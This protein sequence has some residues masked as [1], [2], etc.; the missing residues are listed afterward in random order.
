MKK[1]YFLLLLF[2]GSSLLHAQIGSLQSISP[3]FSIPGQNITTTIT[4]VGTVFQSSSPPNGINNIWLSGPSTISS[5]TWPFFTPLDDEHVDADFS[6]PVSAPI[7]AYDVNVEVTDG[8][9]FFTFYTLTLPGAFNVGTPDGYVQGNIYQ[10]ANGNGVK[11]GGEPDL[12]N[13]T[14]RIM[15]YNYT[16]QTDASGNYSFPVLNGTYTV[17]W[18]VNLNLFMLL[19][20]DSA[21]FTVT[22]NNDTISG[23]D[24]GLKGLLLSVTPNQALRGQTL[25]MSI[26]SDSAF[27][28]SIQQVYLEPMIGC[29]SIL[30]TSFSS[31]TADS[32]IATFN[33]P[34][35]SALGNYKL[36]V[37][38][39]NAPFYK[40]HFL[41]D[42]LAVINGDGA[43]SGFL[44]VDDNLN[45][46]HDA[47][48]PGATSQRIRVMPDNILS[49]TDVNGNYSMQVLN[50]THNVT[51][52]TDLTNILYVNSSPVSYSVTINNDTVSGNDF[53]LI[54]GLVSITPNIGYQGQ[55]LNVT[56]TSR[57]LFDTTGTQGN[58][59]QVYV[60][61]GF[62]T[63]SSSFANI[64][65]VDSNTATATFIIPTSAAYLGVYELYVVTNSGTNTH[66][67]PNA[68]TVDVYPYYASGNIYYDLNGNGTKDAGDYGLPNQRVRL[69]PDIYY[70]FSNYN[71]DYSAGFATGTHSV[72]WF[73]YAGSP[74]IL[75]SSPA[76]YSFSAPG[77][78]NNLDFGLVTTSPPYTSDIYFSSGFPRCFQDVTYYINYTNSGSV[79]TSGRIYLRRDPLMTFVSSTPPP[80]MFNGDTVIWEF[81]NLNPFIWQSIQ[82]VFTMPGPGNTLHNFA[83]IK[84]FNGTSYILMDSVSLNQTVMCSFDPNDKAATPEGVMAP[85]YTLMSDTIEYLIRFQNT[86]NDTAFNVR[87][88]DYIDEDFDLNSF[89][90]VGSSHSMQTELKSNGDLTFT[91]NNILLPDSNVNEPESHGYVSYRINAKAGLPNL[92][93]VNNTGYII[94]DLNAPVVT[95]TTLNTLV[96]VI[97]TS[98]TEYVNETGTA[99]VYPNPV[100]NYSTL[101]FKN[102]NRQTFQLTITDIKGSVVLERQLESDRFII[103]EKSFSPG[104]YLFSLFNTENNTSQHGKF[105]VR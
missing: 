40:S 38:V 14:V 81:T 53:G 102:D 61:K 85:H 76:S 1:I 63:I 69:N 90:V 30:A 33:I 86:G 72:E 23:N 27:V 104:L 96:Y 88:I 92:T 5:S 66:R 48:E 8:P 93:P 32:A 68:F 37:S 57:D 59:T 29:C 74:F 105:V 25:T 7:G 65:A 12:A 60:K 47:G 15:P 19:S 73:P 9:P 80:L 20:S 98:I 99:I 95:N 16:L 31:L 91:F 10:D 13:Q 58:I 17:S 26:N 46:V 43:I 97:P 44:Y 22:V 11:D 94:F 89:Q 18:E 100:D 64:F 41:L 70:Y 4:G 35:N 54:R 79:T 82:A 45:G 101:L 55:T 75:S 6:I 62:Y 52:E 84:P 83:S 56:I 21:S 2:T 71:G 51:F 36:W 103:E 87:I 28:G 49:I 24:F 67:L 39:Y 77:S 3:N 42:A 78:V 34:S 50:G